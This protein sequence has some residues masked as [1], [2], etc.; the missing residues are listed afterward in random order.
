MRCYSNFGQYLLGK[1]LREKILVTKYV[2]LNQ[3]YKKAFYTW[4]PKF[5]DFEIND[6]IYVTDIR[7][8]RHWFLLVL[9]PYLLV[10]WVLGK[11]KSTFRLPEVSTIKNV[12]ITC[13]P[14]IS[15][16]RYTTK[17]SKSIRIL[18]IVFRGPISMII[19]SNKKILKFFWWGLGTPKFFSVGHLS[20]N[21][22][23]QNFRTVA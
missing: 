5:S 21:Y 6:H 17:F 1:W 23:V 12:C 13:M 11:T 2:V 9:C 19:I 3:G 10:K 4:Y 22:T 20:S 8:D 15:V 7:T 14:D 18:I 16:S